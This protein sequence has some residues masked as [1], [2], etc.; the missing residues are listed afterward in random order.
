MIS[1]RSDVTDQM[2]WI[3]A[4]GMKSEA[5]TKKR[6]AI[7]A[8]QQL[9]FVVPASQPLQ[10]SSVTICAQQSCSATSFAATCVICP[11]TRKAISRISPKR[12]RGMLGK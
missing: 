9:V 11:G 12:R 7:L 8:V 3:E 6:G 5:V 2:P 4:R 10:E 1:E